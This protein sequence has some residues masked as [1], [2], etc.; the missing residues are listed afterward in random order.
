MTNTHNFE[1]WMKTHTRRTCIKAEML[2]TLYLCQSALLV[3]LKEEE[4]V[5]LDL[6]LWPLSRAKKTLHTAVDK[7][8]LS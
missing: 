2:T 7:M 4:N 1:L 3:N 8:E 6:K 5:Y